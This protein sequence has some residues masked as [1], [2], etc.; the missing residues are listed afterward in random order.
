MGMFSKR[1]SKETETRSA[2]DIRYVA[3][4]ARRPILRLSTATSEKLHPQYQDIPGK[5]ENMSKLAQDAVP[6]L[7]DVELPERP[8]LSD[9]AN[10]PSEIR[11]RVSYP[12]FWRML[13]LASESQERP[14]KRQKG[15]KETDS[16]SEG[17]VDE[18][19]LAYERYLGNTRHFPTEWKHGL[20]SLE[21]A[22]DAFPDS[23]LSNN[24]RLIIR[25][26]TLS[27]Y[28]VL[29]EERASNIRIQPS[30]AASDLDWNNHLVAGGI[31]L[32]ALLVADSPD[33]S[34]Q[35]E[36]SDI[37]VYVYGLGPQAA[38]EKIKHI[39]QVFRANLPRGAPTLVVRN[40]KTITFY[41]DFPTRRI[42]IVLKLVKSPK[43]VLL[44][45]D[46]DICA[47]GWDGS[48][49]WMLPRA[50]RALETGFNIF[51]MNLIQGHL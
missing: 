23:A 22:N 31:V 18:W 12:S 39:F 1:W 46:L 44:N 8:S 11:S 13:S 5:W 25:P 40:S 17:D 14:A 9:I 19:I 21:D 10:L 47:I 42:Q 37:D 36:S 32:G 34:K 51:T 28:L 48:N 20:V 29:G 49:V 2:A 26:Q 4:S 27:G 33:S 45:F 35:W 41:S 15:V 50:A 7:V 30:V 43:D 24:G 3:N 16:G 6:S 38:T